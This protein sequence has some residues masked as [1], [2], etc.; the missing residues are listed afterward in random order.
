MDEVL[1]YKAWVDELQTEIRSLKVDK[2]KLEHQLDDAKESV[3]DSLSYYFEKIAS[4]VSEAQEEIQEY[5][6]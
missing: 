4:A 6:Q 1:Y 5:M 3:A 2:V